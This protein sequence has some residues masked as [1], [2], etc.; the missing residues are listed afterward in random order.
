[1]TDKKNSEQEEKGQERKLSLS[2]KLI[3]NIKHPFYEDEQKNIKHYIM[4][5]KA[6]N[7]QDS[8]NKTKDLFEEKKKRWTVISFE[9]EDEQKQ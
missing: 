2:E 7:K 9:D 1:M 4:T 5:E 3:R 8:Q 6:R